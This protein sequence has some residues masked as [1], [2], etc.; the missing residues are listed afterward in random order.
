[1]MGKP[2]KKFV[3]VAG[4][5]GVGKSTLVTLLSKRLNWKPFYEPVGENPYLADFYQDMRAWAFHS[6]IF[7]LTQRLGAH[8]QLVAHPTSVL[9]DRTV[10][11]DAEVFA[12]NLY[13]QGLID[14]RDFH[15]YSELY[16]VLTEFLPP[17]DLVIYLRADVP[18]L[19]QRIAQRGRDYERNITPEYLTT[20]NTLYEDWVAR[21]NLC[22]LLTVPAGDLDYVTQSSH[23]DLVVQKVQEKLTGKEEVIFERLAE[24][25]WK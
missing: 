18:V 8:R 7:F 12:R 14:D 9:Q 3:A 21:F 16:H 24:G 10:Y 6:Q 23:L 15:A 22:P 20:L 4:N 13:Q 25:G 2:Q 11:E 5:I 17:P 1:M 19:L